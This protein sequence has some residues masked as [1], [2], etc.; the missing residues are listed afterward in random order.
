MSSKLV[1]VLV[2]LGAVGVTGWA[3]ARLPDRTRVDLGEEFVPTPRVARMAS[4]GF[5]ALIADYYW[6]QAVQVAGAAETIGVDEAAHLGRLVDVVTTLNPQVDHPYRFAAVWLTHSREQVLEGNRLLEKAIAHH[7]DDWR[8]PFYLGFNHFYYLSDFTA[9]AASLEQA[10][11]LAGTPAWVP[12]LVARLKSQQGDI[13]VAAVFL[14]ERLEQTD[15]EE[16][17]ARISTA[18]D[19]IE[20]EYKA[21]MLD[22]ARAAY[23]Q[24]AGRDIQDVGDLVR[25]PYRV[26]ERLPSP[27][28]DALPP[29]LRRGSIW[30]F[31]D[32]DRIVSSY[33]GSRYEVHFSGGN[34]GAFAEPDAGERVGKEHGHGG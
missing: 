6:L 1:R 8:N 15:D 4:F 12:R 2:L 19:E 27:E 22:R 30:E 29:P 9:A 20:I 10:V 13:D 33:L 17:A 18:L 24:L 23:R 7:P 34:P 21:R 28:P 14:R 26:L 11:G 31:D 5:E 16:E 25:D 32:E 3:H